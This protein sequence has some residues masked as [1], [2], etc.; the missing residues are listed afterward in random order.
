VWV[1]AISSINYLGLLD[2]GLRSS[3][4]RYVS[5]EK[6]VGAHDR[7]SEALSAA[8]WVRLQ[9]GGLVLL[10]SWTFAYFFPVWFHIPPELA[11]Q[12]RLA[13]VIIG[14]TTALSM[15]V[16]IFGGV[17]SALNRYDAQT[18]VSLVQLSFRVTGVVLSL[19]RGWGLIGIAVSELIAAA[20]G[21]TILVVLSFRLYPQLQIRLH[22]PEPSMMRQLW[23]YSAY[24]F[25]Q[26]V[27]IQLVYQTDNL[28]VGSFVSASAV[29][30]YAI[31]NSLCR[32]ADQLAGSMSMTFVPAAST[33]DA[34]GNLGKVRT[35]YRLGTRGML[36]ISLPILVTFFLRGRTFI[37]LWMGREYAQTS[38]T[39]LILLSIALLFSLANNTAS[40]IAFG[41]DRHRFVAKCAVVEGLA[42][43]TLSVILVHRFGI[44]GVAV[45]TL[46]PSLVVHLFIWPRYVSRLLDVSAAQVIFRI[47]GVMFA[48]ALPFAAASFLLERYWIP[49]SIASFFLQTVLILPVFAV[50]V[51]GVFREQVRNIALPRLQRLIGAA[52]K[53]TA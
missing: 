41:T 35:L 47:W 46:I 31:G 4:L 14:C 45:G 3:V 43:L 40:A 50:C 2:L 19:H 16:G 18:A 7:A 12:S 9:I 15:C 42:N 44:L 30:F 37:T 20:V 17:L 29:T 13:V 28:V 49:T 24:A 32:Y 48:A 53:V 8:L 52:H 22:R 39:V 23:S 11:F 25:L 6:A 36:A 33:Y 38:G 27:A 10:L 51:F 5:K 1:L 34:T 26:S 21:N